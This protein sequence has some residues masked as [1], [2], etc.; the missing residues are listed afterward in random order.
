[1]PDEHYQAILSLV[2]DLRA[3]YREMVKLQTA[4]S[5][6]LASLTATV[7]ALVGAPLSNRDPAFRSQPASTPP[8]GNSHIANGKAKAEA[9][10]AKWGTYFTIAILALITALQAYQSV[11]KPAPQQS[12][13]VPVIIP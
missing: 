11:T 12:L 1:M 10:A 6:K 4:T 8:S 13:P 5:E 7:N 9:N 2:T 3:D